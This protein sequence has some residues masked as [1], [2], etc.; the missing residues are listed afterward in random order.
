M[1]CTLPPMRRI[2]LL[3]PLLLALQAEAGPYRLPAR[4][5]SLSRTAERLIDQ[6][7]SGQFDAGQRL[8]GLKDAARLAEAAGNKELLLRALRDQRDLELVNGACDAAVATGVQAL[9]LSTS[10][11]DRAGMANDLM[12]L[13]QGYQRT[14]AVEEAVESGK[15]ALFLWKTTNDTTAIGTSS[16]M[17]VDLLLEARRPGEAKHTAEDAL[18]LF[19]SRQDTLGMARIWV[20]QGVVFIQQDHFSEALSVLHRAYRVFE[21]GTADDRTDVLMHLAEA[22]VGCGRWA[23]ARQDLASAEDQLLREGRLLSTP[24]LFALRARVEEG[25][26]DPVAALAAQKRYAALRDSLFNGRFLERVAGLRTLYQLASHER[27]LTTLQE[28]AEKAK[29][30]EWSQGWRTWVIGLSAAVL[31]T[32]IALALMYRRMH[33]AIARTRLKHQV[34]NR[35]AEEIRAKNLE[36]ERQNMRLAE[37]L[38]HEEEK[39]VILKEIHHRVKNN[40]QIASTLLRMQATFAG[41]ERLEGFLHDCQSRILSMALVHEH[42]YKC[43]DLSR[44]NVKAH[45]MALATNVL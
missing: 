37:T 45:V 10:A 29:A 39:D 16:L 3:L 24:A 38:L 27:E 33:R 28:E 8:V 2:A 6:A 7:A 32:L 22:N 40:L 12:A 42:I 19:T 26:G 5:D 15:R 14:G 18:E 1:E 4:R 30:D 11:G 35:Q 23:D 41:D 13:A 36:L 44:V 34:V 21:N 31:I 20:R 17:L 43:G 9:Q 25:A